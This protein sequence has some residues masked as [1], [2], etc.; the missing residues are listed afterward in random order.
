MVSA[1]SST[2]LILQITHGADVVDHVV[3]AVS[4]AGRRVE[5]STLVVTTDAPGPLFLKLGRLTGLTATTTQTV[6]GPDT[7]YLRGA[8]VVVGLI[9]LGVVPALLHLPVGGMTILVPFIYALDA[10]SARMIGDQFVVRAFWRSKNRVVRLDDITRL[11]MLPVIGRWTT[12]RV[13]RVTASGPTKAF[14]VWA[15][16][17]R[18]PGNPYLSRTATM[19]TYPVGPILRELVQ[20]TGLTLDAD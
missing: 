1:N 17:Q 16:R 19:S 13:L 12:I 15:I 9:V 4:V 5:G 2:T 10:P 11:R 6:D 7:R 18:R 3:P 8:V 20:R 14:R